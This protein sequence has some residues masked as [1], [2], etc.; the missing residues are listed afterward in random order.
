MFYK[1]FVIK[2]L[3][4]GIS[5]RIFSVVVCMLG[6]G[7]GCACHVARVEVSSVDTWAPGLN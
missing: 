5:M 2:V 4:I 3:Y 1:V 6:T 7:K